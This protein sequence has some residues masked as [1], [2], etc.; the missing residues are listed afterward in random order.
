ME[1]DDFGNQVEREYLMTTGYLWTEQYPETK[2]VFEDGGKPHSMELDSEKL[3][4][5]WA[6]DSKDGLEFFIINDAIISKLCILGDNVEPCFEGSSITA[7]E[8]S[9]TFTKMDDDFTKTLFS[10]MEDLKFALQGGDT[11]S[12]LDNQASVEEIQVE[13]NF[14]SENQDNHVENE[15][16]ENQEVTEEIS[17]PSDQTEAQ[18]EYEVKQTDD[19]AEAHTEEQ[20]LA[21][22]KV[23]ILPEEKQEESDAPTE[24]DTSNLE[25][26]LHII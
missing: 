16:F 10:M 21:N 5:H 22:G 14:S 2:K 1:E 7:P 11:V 15:M 4:G 17:N 12:E 3:E 23:G 9:K 6:R 26:V 24:G 8:I 19:S 20:K 18:E 13:E 25:A